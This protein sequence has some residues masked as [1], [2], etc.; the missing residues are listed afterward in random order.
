MR[1]KVTAILLEK[2]KA[3]RLSGAT[4]KQIEK[5]YDVSRWVTIH[6]LKNVKCGESVSDTLWRK[7]ELKGQLFLEEK[8]F[9]H[10]LDL[11]DI[12]PQSY[13]DFYAEKGSDRWLVDVTINESKDIVAKSLKLVVGFRCAILYVG[14]D[15]KTFRMV[16]LKEVE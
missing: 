4:Y 9:S 15:L 10:I 13:F 16:E 6:Y 12:S 8:G 1:G 14:H 3:D 2:M 11:N 5:R 7:A